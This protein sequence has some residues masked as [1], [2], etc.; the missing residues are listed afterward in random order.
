[1]D[2]GSGYCVSGGGFKSVSDSAKIAN[3][4][5]TGAG[6]GRNLFGERQCRVR[7]ETEIFGRQAGH[8][9]FVGR[10][11]ERGAD[12]F[13]GL[14][15]KTDKKEFSWWACFESAAAVCS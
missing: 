1:M 4:V 7:Y 3:M 14:M 6:Q 8:Y 15:R 12:Y 10:K 5:M 11:G 2:E 9:G 13:R